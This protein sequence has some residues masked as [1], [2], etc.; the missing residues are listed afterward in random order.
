MLDS[1]ILSATLPQDADIRDTLLSELRK[2]FGDRLVVW[3]G[4]VFVLPE[5]GDGNDVEIGEESAQI[6]AGAG[7]RVEN[8]ES[9]AFAGT[10]P[11]KRLSRAILAHPTRATRRKSGMVMVSRRLSAGELWIAVAEKNGEKQVVFLGQPGKN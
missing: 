10:S 3:A 9:I 7:L 11:E 4:D 1:E 8:G 2:R 5:S 6:L